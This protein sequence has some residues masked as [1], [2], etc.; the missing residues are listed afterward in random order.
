VTLDVSVGTTAGLVLAHGPGGEAAWESLVTAL[1]L[2][3]G[4]VFVLVVTTRVRVDAPGDLVLPL[5]VVAIVSSLAPN[6][7]SGLASLVGYAM[8]AGVV[9]AAGLV[10][11]VVVEDHPSLTSP[12]TLGV[13]A[14]AVL[15]TALVGPVLDQAFYNPPTMSPL[16]RMPMG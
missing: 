9:L 4:L 10:A 8:V 16:M 14:V 7:A 12:V 15:A 3:V 5:A 1:A 2:G 11:V 6:A 13:V